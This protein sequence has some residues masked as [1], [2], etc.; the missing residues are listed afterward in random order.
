M[1]L[2]VMKAGA[3]TRAI[4]PAPLTLSAATQLSRGGRSGTRG[5]G[6]AGTAGHTG[7]NNPHLRLLW[8]H[9]HLRC[10]LLILLLLLVHGDRRRLSEPYTTYRASLL[11]RFAELQAS[12][13]GSQSE[14]SWTQITQEV[15]ACL[16]SS[17]MQKWKRKAS[18]ASTTT[19]PPLAAAIHWI[20]RDGNKKK[21]KKP[22]PSKSHKKHGAW[23][24]NGHTD[25]VECKR[26]SSLTTVILMI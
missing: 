23:K 6:E 10:L 5:G 21:K 26:T 17:Q 4:S 3:S 16:S 13:T 14:L 11:H 2:I 20:E 24:M 9:H 25:V 1:L 15:G 8:Y 18:S 19:S 22:A 12:L 7:I